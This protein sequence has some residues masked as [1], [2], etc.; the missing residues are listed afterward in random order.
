MNVKK[1]VL[2]IIVCFVAMITVQ[3]VYAADDSDIKMRLEK[4]EKDVGAIK[5]QQIKDKEQAISRDTGAEGLTWNFYGGKVSIYGLVDVSLDY[6]N[7][8]LN[9]NVIN[10]THPTGDNG[11]L[12]QIATNLAYIGIRGS[13][14]LG[15]GTLQGVFQIETEVGYSYTPGPNP[16]TTD[17]TNKNGFGSRNSYIGFADYWGALKVGKNDA[18]YKTSTARM[19]P[20]DRTLGDYNSIIGN[21]GGD[22]RAEFDTRISH[23]IWYESP[24]FHGLN[25]AILWSPG[26]N[27]GVENDWWD[28]GEPTCRGGISGPTGTGQCN[29]GSYGDAWSA[30]LSYDTKLPSFGA[31]YLVTAYELHKSVNR[32]GD[33]APDVN[34][35]VAVTGVHDEWAWKIGAQLTID[36]T[37]TVIN[38]IY[39]RTHRNGAVDNFDERTRDTAWYL[40]ITQY[41]NRSKSDQI[42][43]AWA[44]AGKT[45]GDPGGVLNSGQ[46]NVAGPIDNEA[47]MFAL[48]YRHTFPDRR[49]SVYLVGAEQ[50]NHPGA[51]YDLGAS[52]HGI[53]IDDKDEYGNQFAGRNL[54]AIEIG[55]TYKF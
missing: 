15:V 21:T 7:N 29:D 40:A 32:L 2:F 39:E 6:V 24:N 28:K 35:V 11:W 27:R 53:T 20:F 47:N 23:A 13:H 22:N 16:T 25:F 8:G 38:A 44:H 51:H 14:P 19:D 49:T 10:G 31:L 41:L 45:P 37:N 1:Y 26:Q 3:A 33:E 52:G 43:F 36:Y 4:I 46:G 48:G 12:T 34:G 30:S 18:P 54:Q 50:L 55:V 9:E 17:Q 42:D 5:D